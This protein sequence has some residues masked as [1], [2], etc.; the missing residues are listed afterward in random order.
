M[1]LTRYVFMY[2]TLWVGEAIAVRA[3]NF[4]SADNQA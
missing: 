1:P 3:S 4:K 2:L